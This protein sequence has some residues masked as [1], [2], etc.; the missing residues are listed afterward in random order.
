MI[1]GQARL[2]RGRIGGYFDG[3]LCRKSGPAHLD[4]SYKVVLSFVVFGYNNAY[5]QPF[6]DCCAEKVKLKIVRIA[7][8][9]YRVN[10]LETIKASDI[11]VCSFPQNGISGLPII[12]YSALR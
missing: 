4:L 2:D 3:R 10:A 7:L 5:K 1:T 12:K 6:V 8:P 11:G 9:C